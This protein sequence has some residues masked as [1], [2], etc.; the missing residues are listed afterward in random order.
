LLED[1]YSLPLLDVAVNL[2]PYLLAS[3]ARSVLPS[4]Q[5]SDV[6]N[7]IAT[8]PGRGWFPFFGSTADGGLLRQTWKMEDVA[9]K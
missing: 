7:W 9:A 4:T 8:V 2:E 6:Q 1:P 5:Q 3:T